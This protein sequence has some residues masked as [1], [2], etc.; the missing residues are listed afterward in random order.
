MICPME[1]RMIEY[2]E[3]SDGAIALTRTVATQATPRARSG[4]GHS[5]SIDYRGTLRPT[6]TCRTHKAPVPRGHR[7]YLEVRR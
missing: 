3:G 2:K 7:T 5:V 4:L 1:S 6:F